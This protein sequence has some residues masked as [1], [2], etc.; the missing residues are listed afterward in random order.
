MTTINYLNEVIRLI[1][2]V[3]FNIKK[4]GILCT[5][6]HVPYFLKLRSLEL[7]EN[8]DDLYNTDTLQIETTRNLDPISNNIYHANVYTPTPSSVFHEIITS[9]DVQLDE[10][11]FIDLGSGKGKV[12]I[13]ASQFPFKKIIGVEFSS[14]LHKIAGQNIQTFCK[15]IQHKKN[16]F[17][18]NLMDAADYAFPDGKLVIYMFNPFDEKIIYNILIKLSQ[19]GQN[20]Q[21]R[22]VYFNP[23][24]G[25][26][27]ECAGYQLIKYKANKDNTYGWG[28][29]SN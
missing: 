6:R 23:V 20:T 4:D 25:K 17:D 14:K 22:I 29:Y 5:L 3:L 28:I 10:Y 13:L 1:H 16:V 7:K 9:L 12:L 18:L 27:I 11:T 21:T 8:F 24:F 19:R 15:N 26:L 2:G